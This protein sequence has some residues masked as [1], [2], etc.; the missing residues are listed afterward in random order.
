MLGL[1]DAEGEAEL[2]VEHRLEPLFLLL[3]GAV[4][5]HQQHAHGVA[6][7]RVLVLQIVVQPQPLGR[8]V[9]ANDRHPQ[10]G[11]VLAPVLFRQRV[12]V[13]PGLVGQ[14]LGVGQQC[15]PL[16][17]GLAAALPVGPRIFAPV[18]EEADVVVRVL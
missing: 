4:V 7:D 15:L 9:L 11:A 16:F 18:V 8:Q 12:A 17:V 3:L 5:D 2:A 14:G 6:D 1:G 10:V 13:V